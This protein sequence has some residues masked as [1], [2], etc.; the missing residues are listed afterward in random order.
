MAADIL[1]KI[2]VSLG[3]RLLT[4]AFLG[5]VIV[6]S[7]RALSAKTVNKFDDKL[8]MDLSEALGVPLE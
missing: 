6:H 7:L 4:E 3:T 5:K 8:V 1:L 2:M